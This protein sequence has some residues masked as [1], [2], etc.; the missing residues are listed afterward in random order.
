MAIPRCADQPDPPG[1]SSLQT[2][3]RLCETRLNLLALR[4]LPLILRG[5]KPTHILLNNA[6]YGVRGFSVLPTW[7]QFYFA[8]AIK[9]SMTSWRS[10]SGAEGIG[11]VLLTPFAWNGLFYKTKCQWLERFDGSTVFPFSSSITSLKQVFC[12]DAV[13]D[14][15]VPPKIRS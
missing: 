13:T 9:P 7:G 6:S 3:P 2:F 1:L 8:S 4:A 10:S 11:S 15:K 12:K 14:T 5:A